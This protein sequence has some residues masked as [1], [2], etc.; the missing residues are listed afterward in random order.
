MTV[1]PSPN[2]SKQT[3]APDVNIRRI[4]SS[5]GVYTGRVQK[6]NVGPAQRSPLHFSFEHSTAPP[7]P[8]RQFSNNS[9]T[10]PTIDHQSGNGQLQLLTPHSP[11]QVPS[12]YSHMH[13]SNRSSAHIGIP[14]DIHEEPDSMWSY[15]PTT[16]NVADASGWTQIA[17]TIDTVPS[18]DSPPA[19]PM[20]YT[21]LGQMHL[22]GP[23]AQLV[24]PPP[25]IGPAWEQ[26][27]Q[28]RPHY[29]ELVPPVIHVPPQHMY[30]PSTAGED[31]ASMLQNRRPSFPNNAHGLDLMTQQGYSVPMIHASSE[32]PSGDS[33]QQSQQHAFAYLVQPYGIPDTQRNSPPNQRR[34]LPTPVKPQ[35][36]LFF[37]EYTPREPADASRLPPRTMTTQRKTYQ[38]V[39]QGPEN[40]FSSPQRQQATSFEHC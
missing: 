30:C 5:N 10:A 16:S 7:T 39:N 14:E 32:F 13:S 19:T 35:Q 11:L 9:V 1:P 2:N 4:K 38:F 20:D 28:I 29:P 26:S 8:A 18:Y 24:P 34:P 37:H 22:Q 40:L 15:T 17:D 33:R 36:E 31:V 23:P 12:C 25:H 6:C 27:F 3:L 21:Q